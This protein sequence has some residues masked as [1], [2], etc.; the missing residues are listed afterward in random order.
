[1][2]CFYPTKGAGCGIHSRTCLDDPTPSCVGKK[3]PLCPTLGDCRIKCVKA[4]NAILGISSSRW[5]SKDEQPL[6][7]SSLINP[8][9]KYEMDK[10][11]I[12][13][14]G[15]FNLKYLTAFMLV[16]HCR[17]FLCASFIYC[18][19]HRNVFQINFLSWCPTFCPSPATGLILWTCHKQYLIEIQQPNSR[20]LQVTPHI[21]LNIKWEACFK[22]QVIHG[23][24]KW[25]Y[26]PYQAIEEHS[27]ATG[28]LATEILAIE[29]SR[30]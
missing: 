5:G 19:K 4:V 15:Q 28:V 3:I 24:L 29:N 27:L 10:A 25:L 17:C 20:N 18:K 16:L 11:E 13:P 21:R 9:K 2:A 6:V 26:I 22:S 23:C 12:L 30:I 7:C 14:Q 8:L 1:M